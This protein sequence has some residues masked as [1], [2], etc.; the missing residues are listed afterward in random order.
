MAN[1]EMSVKEAIENEIAGIEKPSV[2]LRCIKHLASGFDNLKC[3][4]HMKAIEKIQEFQS[5]T[6]GGIIALSILIGG[7]L[8]GLIWAIIKGLTQWL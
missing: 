7:G 6:K 8:L 1:G 2:E 4:A 5:R 3:E